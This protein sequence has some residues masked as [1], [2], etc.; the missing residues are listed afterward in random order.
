MA[1]SASSKFH[2]IPDTLWH[3]IERLLPSYKTSCQGGRPRLP[4]RRVVGGIV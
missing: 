3:R 2:Q 4:M 1:A